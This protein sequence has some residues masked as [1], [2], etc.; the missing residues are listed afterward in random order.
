MSLE[1]IKRLNPES[2]GIIRFIIVGGV[3]TLVDICV[4][5]LLYFLFSWGVVLA[6]VVAFLCAVTNSYFMNRYWSFTYLDRKKRTWQQFLLF[7]SVS[8]SSVGFSTLVLLHGQDFAPVPV[9]KIATACIT[10]F[11][12]YLGYRFLV[13]A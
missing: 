7:L 8:I 11:I 4:F 12:N 3:N 13:F 5:F 9:L 2:M 10:P 6:N 1:F